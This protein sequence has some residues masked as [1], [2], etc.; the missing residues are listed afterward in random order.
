[1][2]TIGKNSKLGQRY[3]WAYEHSTMHSLFD[4]YKKPSAR[5]I[6]ASINCWLQCAAEKGDNYKITAAGSFT[7]TAAWQTAQGLRVETAYNS[8]IIK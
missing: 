4:A 6:R 5:K 7:F 8:Y 1:M 3:L 2:K